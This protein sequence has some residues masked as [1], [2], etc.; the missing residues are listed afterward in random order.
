MLNEEP[1]IEKIIA[2]RTF[3]LILNFYPLQEE[4]SISRIDLEVE[5]E[6]VFGQFLQ[7]NPKK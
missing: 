2:R 3:H 6:R 1:K 5:V 7:K 4:K